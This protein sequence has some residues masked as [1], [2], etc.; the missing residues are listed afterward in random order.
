MTRPILFL[1]AAT[2]E[3]VDLAVLSIARGD[4]A[5]GP[6]QTELGTFDPAPLVRCAGQVAWRH[7]IAL[8]ARSDAWYAFGGDRYAVNADFVG[9][10]RLAY[11][12]CNGQEHGDA[13]RDDAERNAMWHR[14][15]EQ[16]RDRP[17][18]LLLHGGDQ[19]YAD[20][21]VNAHPAS[22]GWPFDLPAALEDPDGV[23]EAL[24]AAYFD[25]YA[26]QYSAPDFADLAARVPSLA[27][28]DDHDI[29]DGWGSLPQEILESPVGR[30]L[31]EVARAAFL[32]FQ[33]GCGPGEVPAICPDRTGRSLSFVVPLPGLTI[34]APDLRSERQPERVMGAQ[35]WEVLTGALDAVNGAHVL[36]MSSVPALGPRLS[37]LER[38]IPFVPKL[39]HYEDDLRDQWQ[40]RAHRAEWQRFLSKALAVH[41]R[42]DCA[43]TVLSGEIHLA[44]HATMA[45]ASG[46]LH[47]L[48]ASGIAHPAPP[49]AYARGLGALASLGEAPLKGH[50]IRISGV[51]GY[52]SRY[53]AERNYL[54]LERRARAWSALWELEGSGRSERLAI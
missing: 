30:I 1:R 36:L 31:F 16:N 37:I 7:D 10:L 25:H 3:R 53:A 8:P 32:L 46:A 44:T 6:V 49:R 38:L 47:Q 2:A 24:F 39:R 18:Q 17:Y 28:W 48:V 4:A 11:A 19:I 22:A 29:S 9:D 26:R 12:S 5:P 35:G 41:D 15:A 23:R 40:S 21:L 27:M 33:F 14:L 42:A 51:P 34:I 52:G 43:V 50:A 54:V 20:E 13:A 45:G